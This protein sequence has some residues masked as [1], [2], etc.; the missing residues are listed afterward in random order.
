MTKKRAT[1]K[2]NGKLSDSAGI[3]RRDFLRATA[4]TGAVAGVAALGLGGLPSVINGSVL[5]RAEAAAAKGLNQDEFLENGAGKFAVDIPGLPE[6]SANIQSIQVE[7]LTID[8][9]ETT[10]GA[11]WDYRTYAPGDAHYGKASF[12]S[13][14]GKNSKELLQW[15]HDA[16]RGKDVRKN[17]SV[18]IKDRDGSEARKYNLFECFPIKFDPGDYSPSSTTMVESITVKIGR[19]EFA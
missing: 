1:N 7:D 12:R 15:L 9:R 6:T 4:V 16:S 11:D 19:V 14:V 18:I 13:R 17:I 3:S 2:S 5:E 10:T 8:I